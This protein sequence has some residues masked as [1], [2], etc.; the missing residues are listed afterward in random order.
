MTVRITHPHA[1][2][3]DPR[4]PP[5]VVPGGSGGSPVAAD[6]TF[7][8]PDAGFVARLADAYG[9]APSELLTDECPFCDDYDGDAVG[10]HAANAHAEAWDD[11]TEA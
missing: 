3:D 8:A 4:D 5:S 1:L 2:G 11:F 6:G 7:D 9:V 10:Q